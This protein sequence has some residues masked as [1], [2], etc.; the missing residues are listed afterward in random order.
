MPG[1]SATEL[2]TAWKAWIRQ[3][4]ALPPGNQKGVTHWTVPAAAAAAAAAAATT[5]ERVVPDARPDARAD[6]A[7]TAEVWR[8]LVVDGFAVID[9]A[10]DAATVAAAA[11]GA[12]ELRGA[13][14]MHCGA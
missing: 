8:S 12:E 10:L 3:H 4:G 5:A 9:D 7:V 2:Q 1:A 11:A 14:L 6:A 13:G